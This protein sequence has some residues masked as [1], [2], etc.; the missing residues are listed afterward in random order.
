MESHVETDSRPAAQAPTNPARESHLSSIVED[1][2][3]SV[4]EIAALWKLSRD[5][6]RRL[7][8]NE[9]GVLAIAPRQRRGKRGY[10][11]LRIPSSVVERVHRK[12]SLV[13][14]LTR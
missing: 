4:D 14:V 11:T 6:V 2:Y 8:K 5:S 12:L 7:F 9:P 13:K 3:Y 1:A 10:V